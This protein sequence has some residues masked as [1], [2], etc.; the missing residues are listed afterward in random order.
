MT[1]AHVVK[2]MRTFNV[3]GELKLSVAVDVRADSLEGAVVEARKLQVSD[4]VKFEGEFIDGELERI[5]SVYE[6]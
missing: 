1:A 2:K 3:T 4:F 6:P 5:S